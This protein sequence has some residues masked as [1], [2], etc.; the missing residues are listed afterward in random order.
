MKSQD[1]RNYSVFPLKILISSSLIFLIFGSIDL[2]CIL[3]ILRNINYLY[4]FMAL[5]ITTANVV[6]G[7]YRWKVIL[8]VG[9]M[10]LQFKDILSLYF[11]G[12]FFNTFVPGNI[13]GDILRGYDL[14]RLS[15][16]TKESFISVLMD[17]VIALFSLVL[18]CLVSCFFSEQLI[19]NKGILLFIL[20]FFC[21]SSL[22]L[23]F[24]F[25]S[26]IMRKFGFI[27]K[28]FNHGNMDGKVKEAYYH[29]L[30][31]KGEKEVIVKVFLI[32]IFSH[33]VLILS[34]Y[35]LSLSISSTVNLKYFFLFVPII[36]FLSMIPITVSGLGVREGGFAYFFTIV[37]MSKE[38]AL[39]ISLLFF[40]LL[41][42][43]GLFGGMI[44]VFRNLRPSMIVD[45]ASR[46]DS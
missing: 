5:I 13:G 23:I 18:I 2:N 17:R 36:T 32:S 30:D 29:I 41:M 31:Y 33:V 6:I 45:T 1:L 43:N 35:I 16:K 37:G 22:A 3:T 34:I 9:E 7:A 24:F 21:I 4:F 39:I 10:D 40:I 15:G 28:I 27:L 19:P 8:K 12:F 42:L 14:R 38:S 11:V 20:G 46:P 25:N 44:Y 26:N